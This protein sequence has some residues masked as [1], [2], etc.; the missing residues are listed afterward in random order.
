[1][2]RKQ[3]IK[4]LTKRGI[5]RINGQELEECLTAELVKKAME[6]G[7]IKVREGGDESNKH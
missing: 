1:M 6:L 3:I 5:I 7:I 2:T 4:I